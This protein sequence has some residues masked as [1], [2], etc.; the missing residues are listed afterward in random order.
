MMTWPKR[1]K[2]LSGFS[3]NHHLNCVLLTGLDLLWYS[4]LLRQKS[5]VHRH[6]DQFKYL[7]VSY[8]L[9]YS[10]KLTWT[11]FKVWFYVKFVSSNVSLWL[12]I[13]SLFRYCVT[14][15]SSYYNDPKL[16]FKLSFSLSENECAR[17][18]NDKTYH[19]TLPGL[20]KTFTWILRCYQ[21]WIYCG[22]HF[23]WEKK[24]G[25]S[26]FWSHQKFS[27]IYLCYSK[28]LTWTDSKVW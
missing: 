3:K 13:L 12:P 7:A 25:S 17:W 24:W 15:L 23:C 19:I 8:Y 27:G 26:I 22:T 1:I 16:I 6:F 9:C 2:L 4:F 5:K 14:K 10:R 18:W 20:P 11:Q 21:D 28:S